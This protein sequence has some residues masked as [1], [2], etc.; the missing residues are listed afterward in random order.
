MAQC[1]KVLAADSDTLDSIPTTHRL[2]R[3]HS[4]NLSS[5]LYMHT[6]V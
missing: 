1:V 5:D 4:Y 2:E 3:I 6:V